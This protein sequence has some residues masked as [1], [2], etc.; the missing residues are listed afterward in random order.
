MYPIYHQIHDFVSNLTAINCH[1]HHERD[2]FFRDLGLDALLKQSY[3]SWC[4]YEPGGTVGSRNAYLDKVRYK[5]YFR[6]LESALMAV[7]GFDEP[8]SGENWDTYDRSIR[9]EHQ[10]ESWHLELLTDVCR[11]ETTVLDCYWQPGSDNG[12]PGV[13]S[14]T[15]RFDALLFASRD[16]VNHNGS[17]AFNLHGWNGG[18]FDEYLAF[19]ENTI[20]TAIENGACALKN[21]VAYDR[22]LDYGNPS[23]EQAEKFFTGRSPTLE[24]VVNFQDY[25]FHYIS[26]IAAQLD[27]TIQCHTGM[28]ALY[29]TR[30]IN[31]LSLIQ[32]HPGTRYSLMHGS[33]PWTSDILAFLDLCPNVFADIC[34]LPL[35][36][37][38]AAVET[39]HKLIEVGTSE[40]VVWGCDTWTGEESYGA[41]ITMDHVLSKVLTQKVEDGYL[42]VSDAKRIS[43]NV[44]YTNPKSLFS[45]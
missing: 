1:S 36:S 2:A 27:V 9:E 25:I 11:Y 42:F 43:E 44:L 29:K 34:W 28:G 3:V 12:H 21:A 37:P 39:L 16:T 20:H 40:R 4:G 15:F 10:D 6:S 23:K 18:S 26:D 7:Y 24:D 45:L 30:A 17:N 35:L 5:S 41:R 8:L 19:V 31:M 13:F 22:A 32:A 33:F 14:P 38:T